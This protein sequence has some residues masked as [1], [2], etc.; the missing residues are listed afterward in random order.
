M[1]R[2]YALATVSLIGW[3]LKWRLQGRIAHHRGLTLGLPRNCLSCFAFPEN[4]PVKN[5]AQELETCFKDLT[6][7]VLTLNGSPTRP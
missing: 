1:H 3:S 7:L 6:E 5:L 4:E 2:L